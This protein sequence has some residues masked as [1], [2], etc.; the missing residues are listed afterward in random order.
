MV[1]DANIYFV[2]L[3]VEYF[4]FAYVIINLKIILCLLFGN[5]CPDPLITFSSHIPSVVHMN[6]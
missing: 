5:I 1:S 2:K 3:Q 6:Y 4:I